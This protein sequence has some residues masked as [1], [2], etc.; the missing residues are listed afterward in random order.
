MKE[1]LSHTNEAN[2]IQ[3][4]LTISTDIASIKSVF[5]MITEL[6]E[7]RRGTRKTI[8]FNH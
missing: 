6:S 8:N 3:T 2:E 4:N 1:M 5:C 7:S